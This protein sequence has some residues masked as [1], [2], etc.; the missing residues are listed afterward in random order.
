MGTDPLDELN[1]CCNLIV[2]IKEITDF[3]QCLNDQKLQSDCHWK[4]R[5]RVCDQGFEAV[6]YQLKGIPCEL[7]AG[8][9][10]AC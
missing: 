2:V 6:L 7:H 4:P 1:Q 9:L 10:I 8:V 3:N 5:G